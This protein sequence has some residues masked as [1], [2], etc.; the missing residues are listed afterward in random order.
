L[1]CYCLDM[2]PNTIRTSRLEQLSTLDWDRVIQLS[3]RHG[4]TPSLYRRL[5]TLGPG[6]NIPASIEQRLRGVYLHSVG[7]GICLYHELSQVLRMLQN[8]NIPVIVLKGAFLAEVVYGNIALRSM[9]DVDLLV[10]KSD[11]ARVEKILPEMGYSPSRRF[12]IEA[13]CATHQHL[14]PFIKPGA[15]PLEIHWIIVHPTGPFR[16]DVDGLW[17]RARPTLIAGV[18]VL[19]LSPEDLLLHLCL[20]TSFQHRFI[21]G[22]RALCDISETLWHYRDEMDWE[23][24]RLR[25][26]QWGAGKCGYLTLHLARELLGALVPDDVLS[27]LEPSGLHPRF[28]TW[29]REQI[30]T[31]PDKALPLSANLARIWGAD[32]LQDKAAAFLKTAF[33]SRESM[34]TMYPAPPSSRRIYLYYPVRLKDLLLQYGRTAWRLLCRD[35]EALASAEREERGN[36]LVDWLTSS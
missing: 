17:K 20:H 4:V 13:E 12:W 29:A 18:E 34:A 36:A 35:E 27:A 22:L 32:R 3:A 5:K 9:G 2:E 8:D 33:P 16:I 11:L 10:E 24:V 28:V 1:L 23:Q 15:A 19:V 6:T 14:P 21:I 30:F 26:R 31:E 7:R 25:A